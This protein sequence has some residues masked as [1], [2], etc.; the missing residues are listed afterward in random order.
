MNRPHARLGS[1]LG[2]IALAGGCAAPLGRFEAALEEAGVARFA[3][4]DA[5]AVAVR[6]SLDPGAPAGRGAVVGD[7]WVLTVDHVT[8]G[9]ETVHVATTREAG[10]VAA[11]VARR[12]PASPE[13]LALLEVDLDDGLYGLLLGFPGF[14]PDRHLIAGAGDPVAVLT[15]RGRLPWTAG[16]LEPGDS[17]SPVLD[18]AGDLVGV[19]CGRRGDTGVYVALPA[20][21]TPGARGPLLAARR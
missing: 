2:L 20:A 8:R 7:R 1:L 13:P 18:A 5:G 12:I 19:V 4:R 9:Q 14:E 11:R 6:A 15:A 17:G 21:G 10:W 16:V 3:S